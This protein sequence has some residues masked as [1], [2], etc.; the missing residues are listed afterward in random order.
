[1]RLKI[2]L[3]LRFSHGSLVLQLSKPVFVSIFQYPF[4]RSILGL[5]HILPWIQ[6][7]AAHEGR[8]AV[9]WIFLAVL[10]GTVKDSCILMSIVFLV[11]VDE[12][13]IRLIVHLRLGEVLLVADRSVAGVS[14]HRTCRINNIIYSTSTRLR[15]RVASN[16][17]SCPLRTPDHNNKQQLLKDRPFNEIV[18]HIQ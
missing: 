11:D 12:S 15:G 7:V 16:H 6:D 8:I 9:L 17:H 18:L 4:F 14:S 10:I 3:T 5:L 13:M 1:M 2:Q